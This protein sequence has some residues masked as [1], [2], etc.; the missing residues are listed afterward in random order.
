MERVK[1][2]MTEDRFDALS[3]EMEIYE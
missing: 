3:I 1:I 2:E